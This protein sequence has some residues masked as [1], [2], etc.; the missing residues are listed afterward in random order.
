MIRI[1]IKIRKVKGPA[2]FLMAGSPVIHTG[3]TVMLTG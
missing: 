1:R 2:G 3:N